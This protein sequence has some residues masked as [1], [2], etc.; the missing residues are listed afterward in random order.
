MVLL[1]SNYNDSITDEIC[2]WLSSEDKKFI[3]LN[4]NQVISSVKFNFNQNSFEISIDE[5]S[6]NLNEIKAVFYRNGTISYNT[7]DIGTD[8]LDINLE[9][10]YRRECNSITNFIFYYL[11]TRNIPIYGNFFV[12]EV[13]KLEVLHLANMLGFKIP[14]TYIFSEVFDIKKTITQKEFITKALSEMQPIINGDGLYLNYTTQISKENIQNKTKLIPTL[15]QN[16]IRTDFEIR[17]FFFENKIWSVATFDFENN[18][19]IRNIK[20]VDKKYIPYELPM[21]LQK[22]ILKLAKVLKLKCGTIDFLRTRNEYFFLEVNPLGQFHQV[23]LF[24]NYNIGKYI[25]SLL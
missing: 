13:N 20:E 5:V 6:Y 15:L 12:K 2:S 10:F 9:E 22:K 3:R 7:C 16:K 21:S 25:A 17:T 23:S 8:E 11:Q 14:E 24:G 18:V 19:D 4:E 1:V